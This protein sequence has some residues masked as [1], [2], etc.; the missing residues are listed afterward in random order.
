MGTV[1]NVEYNVHTNDTDS[2]YKVLI[3]TDVDTL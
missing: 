3:Q 1:D 2:T